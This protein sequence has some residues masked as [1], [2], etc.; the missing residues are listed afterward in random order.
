MKETK[1]SEF[2]LQLAAKY[3]FGVAMTGTLLLLLSFPPIDWW[4]LAW[5]ALIPW[6]SLISVKKFE[7]PKPFRSIWFAGLI[8]WALQAYY[9][10]IPHPALWIAWTMLFS[11]LSV[12]PILF[13]WICRKMVHGQCVSLMFAAP[14]VFTAMEW[15]RAH[16]L[17]GF[18]FCMLANSQYRVP[19]SLQFC[20]I[21]GAYGLTLMMVIFTSA[22]FLAVIS[23]TGKW[24]YV[25]NALVS[26]GIVLGYGQF[27]LSTIP[28][29]GDSLDIAV[30]QGSIDTR[31]PSTRAEQEADDKQRFTEY[32]LL[33]KDWLRDNDWPVP[34]LSLIHI[35][36]PTRPY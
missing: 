19:L 7:A 20:D 8:Y 16:M 11:Y 31:F 24:K 18:G 22:L 1:K 28:T 17:T 36:E 9:I 34:D 2:V 13:V 5:V 3:P 33:Q 15:V 29:N 32:Q 25:L 4:P 35:S 27:R 14:V 30:M 12:Y 6:L 10:S 23:Q 21:A 26:L